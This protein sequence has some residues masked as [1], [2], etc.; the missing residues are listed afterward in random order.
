MIKEIRHVR[1]DQND[2]WIY[3]EF[4]ENHEIIGINYC[5]CNNYEY[6]KRKFAYKSE[7]LT[8]FYKTMVVDYNREFSKISLLEFVNKVCWTYYVFGDLR[9][10]YKHNTNS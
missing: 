1:C 5:Q 7:E 3:L 2:R 9:E 4:N 6:F 8:E 10:N